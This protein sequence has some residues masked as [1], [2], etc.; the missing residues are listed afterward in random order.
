MYR[1]EA[2][3]EM[4]ADEKEAKSADKAIQQANFETEYKKGEFALTSV[5][6][7]SELMEVDDV[8]PRHKYSDTYLAPN[9]AQRSLAFKAMDK[10]PIAYE[11]RF[12][13]IGRITGGP[14][15]NYGKANVTIIT[16]SA[17]AM[18]YTLAA[19]I[20]PVGMLA[21]LA[22][23]AILPVMGVS[24]VAISTIAPLVNTIY[25]VTYNSINHYKSNKQDKINEKK[26]Q[27]D[28]TKELT[29]FYSA[30]KSTENLTQA[31]F[32]N[33]CDKIDSLILYANLV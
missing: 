18:G 17:K 30:T 4:T 15:Y 7:G 14:K 20:S 31:Q 27:A 13:N 1:T 21:A 2:S 23:P 16:S 29:R 5:L 10:N 19:A 24:L 3:V 25:G 26:W 28:L 32:Q 9:Y 11:S 8:H 6:V 22:V 12:G 33:E